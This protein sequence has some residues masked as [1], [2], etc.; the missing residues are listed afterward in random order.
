MRS[1]NDVPH[2]GVNV[3]ERIVPPIGTLVSEEDGK[4]IFPPCGNYTIVL[5]SSSSKPSKAIVA[6]G[7]WEE[8]IS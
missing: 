8:P 5:K 4:F 3:F 1:T 2:G 7:W 6:F